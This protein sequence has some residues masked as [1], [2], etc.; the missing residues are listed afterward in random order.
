MSSADENRIERRSAQRFPY[1][2]PVML[3][4]PGSVSGAG[5][6]QDLSSRG[7]MIWTDVP[8]AEG[9]LIEMTVV[10]PAEITLTEDMPVRCRARVL[11]RESSEAGQPAAVALR[12][13]HYEFL[14]GASAAV[15]CHA[16][17]EAELSTRNS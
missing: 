13:E 12:I 17:R 5:F 11:R 4:L 14:Y 16:G 9:Q 10:M 8:L 1:Q 3:R 2:L 6:T 15:E 7:A